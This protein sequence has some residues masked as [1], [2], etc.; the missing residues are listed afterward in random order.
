MRQSSPSSVKGRKVPETLLFF[1]DH[2]HLTEPSMPRKD[3]PGEAVPP[4]PTGEDAQGGAG[5]DSDAPAGRTK[6][7]KF[8]EEQRMF[9]YSFLMEYRQGDKDSRKALL[10]KQVLGKF[11]AKWHPKIIGNE[12]KWMKRVRPGNRFR[13]TVNLSD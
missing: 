10:R 9:L 7:P 11:L 8:T 1:L 13:R 2:H 6:T 12:K 5:D 4:K 3:A